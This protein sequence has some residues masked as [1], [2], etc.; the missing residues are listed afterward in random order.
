MK[1]KSIFTALALLLL[2]ST[3]FSQEKKTYLVNTIAF[4]NL[5]NLFDTVNDPNIN[6]EDFIYTPENYKDKLQKLERVISQ[7]GTGTEQKK[8]SSDFRRGRN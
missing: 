5:E 2:I 3:G 6:D 8:F 7:I 4:Y 1:I